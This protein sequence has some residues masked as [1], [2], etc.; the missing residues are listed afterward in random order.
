MSQRRKGKKK[1]LCVLSCSADRFYPAGLVEE[2][3]V[4]WPIRGW[5][6]ISR[7]QHRTNSIIRSNVTVSKKKYLP[8]KYPLI[9]MDSLCLEKVQDLFF[10]RRISLV[11]LTHFYVKTNGNNQLDHESTSMALRQSDESDGWGCGRGSGGGEWFKV[12]FVFVTSHWVWIVSSGYSKF[13][14]QKLIRRKKAAGIF[15]NTSLVI[16]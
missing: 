3:R 12:L 1:K 8:H 2:D 14:F 7:H 16:P 13:F 15:Q 4:R 5:L 10:L 6:G 11:Q 9:G